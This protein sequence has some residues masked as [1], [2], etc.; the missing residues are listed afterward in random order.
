[1]S[2][3]HASRLFY[4][5]VPAEN[6][7]AVGKLGDDEAP[8]QKPSKDQTDA[9]AKKTKKVKKKSKGAAPE[10]NGDA[11][12]DTDKAEA[13]N[14]KDKPKKDKL[15]KK[16]K[17]ADAD[18]PEPAAVP[19]DPAADAPKKKKKKKQKS[20]GDAA[21][22]SLASREPSAG[23]TGRASI[24]ASDLASSC[25]QILKN[26]YSEHPAVTAMSEEAVKAF[27]DEREIVV[28]GCSVRPVQEFAQA[29]LPDDLLHAL[30][31]FK[32][33][34][35]IQAQCW[36]IAMSGLDLI[37][38]AATGSGAQPPASRHNSASHASGVHPRE[39]RS[40]LL[41]A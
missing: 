41:H 8:V 2:G 3:V 34:S 38:I 9:D 33:P 7:S 12:P 16:R 14:G 17:H 18:A 27:L 20:N 11:N 15:K 6:K 25:P 40:G 29:G 24:G 10:T 26:T 1:M 22:P 32:S 30:K 19:A 4:I 21:A 37:G 5:C 35:P 23:P 13:L 36:P 28:E 31:T 39:I